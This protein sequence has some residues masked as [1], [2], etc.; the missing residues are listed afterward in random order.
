MRFE[1]SG[2]GNQLAKLQEVGQPDRQRRPP[3]TKMRLNPRTVR[4][5]LRM[6]LPCTAGLLL[7]ALPVHAETYLSGTYRCSTVEVAGKT[8]PCKAPSLELKSDGSYKMLSESGTYEIVAGRWLV[9][10]AA[11]KHGRARLD[12]STEIVFEFVSG[13]RKSKITYRRKYQRPSGW[14]AS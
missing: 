3:E 8:A 10:S 6:L 1:N 9:L 13:G 7:A 12:G 2:S 11:K 5:A 14:V 4:T